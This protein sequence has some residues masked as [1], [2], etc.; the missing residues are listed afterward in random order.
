MAGFGLVFGAI[1]DEMQDLEGAAADWYARMGGSEQVLDAYQ[2]SV[3]EM[4]G[5]GRGDLRGSDPAP[6]ARRGGRRP[7]RGRSR[8]VGEPT[9]LAVEPPPQR[10]AGCAAPASCLR[11]EH[12]PR[13]RRRA[14]RCPGRA[15]C[16]DRSRARPAPGHPADRGH[17]HRPH[18]VAAASSRR[19]LLGCCFW[20]RSCSGRSSAPPRCSCRPGR[21]TSRHSRTR[22]SCRPP[23]SPPSPSSA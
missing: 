12:G 15:A 19:T 1:I 16:A 17:S 7:A 18:R 3:T 4:A 14:R 10:R 13:C 11:R 21:K 8:C 23:I 20:L 9:A 2:A 22:R 6:D 5:H